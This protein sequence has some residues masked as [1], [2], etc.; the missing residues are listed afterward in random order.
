ML[1]GF[2]V[3]VMVLVGFFYFQ[4]GVFTAFTMCVNVFVAGLVAF[5]FWEPLADLLEPPLAGTFLAGY[6]DAMCLVVLFCVTLGLLRT[7]TNNL[8]NRV[9][10]HPAVA[11][12]FG[13]AALGLVG[14]YLVAGFM[15]CVL[16]TLPLH[17][18]FLGFDW[19]AAPLDSALR[20]LFPPDRVWL[21]LM[22]RAGAYP[23]SNRED[24]NPPDD[25][26][27]YDLYFT[28][29]R[30]GTFEIRYQ[31]YR[32]YGDRRDKL[33]YLGELDREIYRK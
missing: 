19:R 33:P 21:A 27:S 3:A 9:I 18:N 31:R 23:L 32:R 2:T 5:N 22:R 8:A 29:D 1:A 17:E 15:V 4:E 28:F 6:E 7:V 26:D 24:P 10:D 20:G 13:G 12:Q 11:Q 30:D 14:G 25:A 16:Q